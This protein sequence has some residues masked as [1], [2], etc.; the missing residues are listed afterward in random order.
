MNAP[1]KQN[2]R[3]HELPVVSPKIIAYFD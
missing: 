2:L 3:T 1:K